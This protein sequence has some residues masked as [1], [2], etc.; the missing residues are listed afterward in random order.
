VKI[1]FISSQL[2]FADTRCG[3]ARRLY[4]YA[5]ALE[6]RHDL[7]VLCVDGNYEAGDMR[8]EHRTEFRSFLCL[9]LEIPPDLDPQ[10]QSP[11]DLRESLSRRRGEILDF[12]GS[13]DYDAVLL[14]FP[15][16][17]SFLE[18]LS[19]ASLRN[20]TYLEDDLHTEFVRA[21]IALLPKFRHRLRLRFTWLRITLAFYR[22]R[23]RHIAKVIA[24]SDEEAALL[25]RF[26][27]RRRIHILGNGFDLARYPFLPAIPSL[28]VGYI[29]NYRHRPNVDSLV[30][31]LDRLLPE[32]K[33]R[34]GDFRIVLAGKDLPQDLVAPHRADPRV[35]VMRDVPEAADFYRRISIFINPIVSG[36]GM[37]SKLVEAAAFGR[38]MVS[39]RL[40]AEGA[41]GM[42]ISV[43]DQPEAIV[44]CC[45]A[46]AGDAARYAAEARHNR[47]IVERNYSIESVL[48][49]VEAVLAEPL[50]PVPWWRRQACRL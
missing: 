50:G 32:L 18:F 34:G 37:R 8:P 20:V 9:P 24:V 41:F 31:I 26:I 42:K 44:R 39:T 27:P 22:D 2:T 36:K 28:A 7:K 29:G 17:L 38:P 33:K 10:K 3:G 47:D 46:L 40:G 43:A 19:P 1:L 11:V 13:G 25:G 4:Y 48:P 16:A 23:F 12:L 35:E 15:F 45:E 5:R 21:Q 6:R 14:A 30:F 49:R